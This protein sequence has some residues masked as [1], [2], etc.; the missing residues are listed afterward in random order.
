VTFPAGTA[1]ASVVIN[2]VA[3]GRVTLTASDSSGLGYQSGSLVVT[4]VS[5]IE[6]REIGTFYQ[7]S[8]FYVNQNETHRAQVFLSDPAPAGGLGVTFVYGKPGTSTVSPAPA[9]IPAGQLA[10]DIVISGVAPGT[11]S[12]VPTSGGFVGKFSRVYVAANKLTLNRAYPYTGLLGI[13]QTAQPYVSITYSMDHNLAFSAVLSSGIGTVQTPDT[14]RSG[15]YNGFFTVAAA[16]PGKTNL[17]VSA[18]G[19]VAATDSMTFT[20]AHLQAIGPPTMIAGDPSR[21]YWYAYTN[22]S[23]SGNHPVKDTLV[24]TAVSRNPAAVAVDSATLRVPAGSGGNSVPNALRALPAAGGDSAWIVLSAAGYQ[25]D[26]FKVHVTKPA[27]TFNV[28]YPYSAHVG[29]GTLY[30]NA[31]Y[32][33]IPYVRTDTFTVLFGHTRRGIVSGPD[34]VRIIKGQISASFNIVGDSLGTDTIFITRATGYVVTP[35]TLVYTVGPIHVRP[36]TYPG[37][38]NY[39]ISPP[40]VVTAVVVDS[41]TGYAF[42]LVAPLRVTLASSKPAEFTLDSG[43]VTI[44]SGLTYSYTHPDTLRFRGVDTVG[45]RIL[46]SAPGSTPDS[47]GLIKVF[48][49]PLQI[50]RAYPGT[51]GRG[52]REP[53]NTVSLVGGAAPGPV[54][55]TLQRA[56]RA[57]D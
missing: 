17:T 18:P 56:N 41:A 46:S 13:G 29:I 20:T 47:S 42:P 8:T 5:T 12:V 55:V 7:Q 49:T 51:V 54:A 16:A 32:V 27:L 48:P 53:F 10:A 40:T 19:W 38:T 33:Q 57:V 24:V 37:V 45:A 44:D 4:V 3:A 36:Y 11:D 2:G 21:G 6:F 1:G 31:G 23:A 43:A 30:Q 50:N 28:G 15:G 25:S 35:D 34:S 9:I 26:S 14:I 39:T 52:L 22:D